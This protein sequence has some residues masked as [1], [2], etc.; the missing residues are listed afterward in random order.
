MTM[1]AKVKSLITQYRSLDYMGTIRVKAFITML[2]GFCIAAFKII[3]SVYVK[4][5]IWAYSGIYTICLAVCRLL[6]FHSA[7]ED[8]DGKKKGNYLLAVSIIMLF[9]AIFFDECAMIRQIQSEPNARYPLFIIIVATTYFAVSYIFAI[10]GL[11]QTRK[12]KR[13]EF[14]AIKAIGISGAIMNLVLCQRMILS[15][16]SLPDEVFSTINSSFSYAIGG[17]LS[18]T[19]IVLLIK[20]C[21][22]RK[23]EKSQSL[24]E[25]QKNDGHGEN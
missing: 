2:G 11:F 19:A 18:I 3:F 14:F 16:L 6:F 25:T 7:K 10:I 24:P 17:F 1:I 13:L 5:L 21:L 23:K 22:Y 8:T 4:S 15:C 12:N 20:C 9:S